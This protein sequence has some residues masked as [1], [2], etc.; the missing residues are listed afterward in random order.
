[1][2]TRSP[3]YVGQE[4]RFVDLSA[5]A[6]VL[7]KITSREEDKEKEMEDMDCDEEGEPDSVILL[8]DTSDTNVE[9]D[10][11]TDTN[12]VDLSSPVMPPLHVDPVSSGNLMLYGDDDLHDGWQLGDPLYLYQ[13]FR[14]K[15]EMQHAVKVQCMKAHRTTVVS[16]SDEHR[17]V[18]KCRNH[19]DSCPWYMRAM[20]PKD[21]NTWVVNKWGKDHTCLNQGLTRDHKQ[22]DSEVVCA[23]IISMLREDPTLKLMLIQERIQRLY[24]YNITYKKAWKAKMKGIVKL[25]GDWEKSYALLLNWLTYMT[26]CNVGSVF[27]LDTDQCFDEHR[28]YTDK[29]VF[30]RVFFWIFYQCIEAFK[31]CKPIIQIDGTHL[32]RKYKGTILIATSQDGNGYMLP[33]AFVV[34]PPGE[35]LEDWSWFLSLIR[36]HVTHRQDICLISDLHR[37]IIRA[38]H[39]HTS[40]QPQFAYNMFCLRHIGSKFN[41]KFKDVELKKTLMKLGY[42]SSKIQFDMRFQEFIDNNPEVASWIDLIPKKQCCRSYDDEGRKFGHMT[43]NLSKCVNKVLRGV[44]YLPITSLVKHTYNRLIEYFINKREKI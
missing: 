26:Q 15:S 27:K 1:M 11:D 25:F 21:E 8:G 42:M 13:E 14:S 22:L 37:S 38:V 9:G 20:L 28:V 35:K 41:T 19:D 16:K 24:G 44:H 17:F 30:H 2:H 34:V 12:L 39:D 32:Y 43:T 4:D 33:I 6:Q 3:Q 18:M 5:P 23:T 36:F 10:L 40:W 31:Y 29:V 7:S